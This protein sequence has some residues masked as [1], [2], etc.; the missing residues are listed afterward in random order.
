MPNYKNKNRKAYYTPHHNDDSNFEY[1]NTGRNGGGIHKNQNRNGNGANRHNGPPH[2]R[3]SYF[4]PS[5]IK[6][7]EEET[8]DL[9]INQN[10]STSTETHNGN[11]NNNRNG[12]DYPGGKNRNSKKKRNAMEKLRNMGGK[13]K[14]VIGEDDEKVTKALL[15]C[16]PHCKLS[17]TPD[18]VFQLIVG[19]VQKYFTCYDGDRQGLLG[20]YNPKVIFSLCLNMTNEY[21]GRSFRFVESVLKENRNL[22]RII[23]NDDYHFDKR[24]KLLHIGYIDTVNT[25]CKLPL[26]EHEPSSFKLDNCFF[27]N[28]MINFSLSGVFKEGKSTDNVRPL[29]SFHRTFVCI[30]DPNSQMTIVNEQFTIS[31]VSHGQYKKYFAPKPKIEEEKQTID[32]TPPTAAGASVQVA[33]SILPQNTMILPPELIGLSEIQ[34]LMI[35]QF[36]TESRLNLEWSKHC[37]D[38]SKWI[39]EDAAKAFMQF[40][41]SIPIAAYI[42]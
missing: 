14:L 6:A 8:E 1:H 31:N 25:L 10:S 17:S 22:K 12:D 30:P 39:Y 20:A 37:L 19:Y 2:I 32:T 18:E 26:T 38:H 28:N 41:D 4:N 13:P 21:S 33:T 27:S 23:G 40:K 42:S 5:V 15:P 16:T 35:Q 9:H 29:R 34:C 36:S 3:K 7:L 11:Y 24:A